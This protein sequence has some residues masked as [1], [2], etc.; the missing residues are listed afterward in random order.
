MKK[1]VTSLELSKKLKELGVYDDSEF[2][3]TDCFIYF[4]HEP[5]LMTVRKSII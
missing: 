4:G 2:Y 5:N 3:W 1:Y